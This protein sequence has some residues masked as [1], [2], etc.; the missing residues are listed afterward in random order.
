MEH[1]V[2]E[3]ETPINKAQLEELAADGWYLITVMGYFG[4]FYWYFNRGMW[5]E[6]TAKYD[7]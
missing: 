5:A 7:S 6:K 4:K 2:L 3:T 1:K